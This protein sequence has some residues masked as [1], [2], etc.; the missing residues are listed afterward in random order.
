MLTKQPC[1]AP[2]IGRALRI[3]LG[4]VLLVYAAP[5]YLRV[6]LRVVIESLLLILALIAMYA[7]I[8]IVSSRFIRPI[9]GHIIALG[10]LV[11]L[12]I[13]GSSRLPILGDRK[14]QLA[15]VTFLGVSLVVA[16]VRAHPGCELVAIP[17]AFFRNRAEL[18]CL[19]FS[20][21]DKLERQL[22]DKRRV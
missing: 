17:G 21:L 9:L 14:G 4:L 19:I 22:R 13:A 15:A 18:P 20:P 1:R 8:L 6:S 10:L 2:P 12:Y 11:A 3:L 7:V 5:V 16:G